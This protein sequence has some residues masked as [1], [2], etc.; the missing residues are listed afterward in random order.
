MTSF[1]PKAFALFAVLSSCVLGKAQES[2]RVTPAVKV[3]DKIQSAVLPVFCSSKQ[4]EM[5]AGSATVIH[6]SGFMLT[7]DH[8][9]TD[10]AGVVLIG[11]E[12][13]EYDVVGRLPERDVAILK[14]R[15]TKR[16][17]SVVRFGTS[18]DL[19]LGEPIVVGGN[20]GGRGIVFS[21]GTINS[22]M[23]EPS[24]PNILIKSYWRN[25]TAE[26]SI[27]RR[28]TT[29]GRP[30]FIQFDATTN[31]GNSGGPVVN[32]EA[33]LIGLVSQKSFSEEGINWAVPIDRI[34]SL[35]PH[36]VPSEEIGDFTT[37][38][39][40]D[41]LAPEALVESVSDNSPASNAGLKKGDVIQSVNGLP[42]LGGYEWYFA[43]WGH[44]PG[45]KLALSLKR[46]DSIESVE[47]QLAK[48]AVPSSSLK[49]EQMTE[50]VRFDFYNGMYP[51]MPDFSLLKPERSGNLKGIELEGVISKSATQKYAIVYKGFI[52][53][54]K[55]GLYRFQLSSDDGSKLY[56]NDRL[57]IDNDLG[58]PFQMLSRWARVPAGLVPFRLEYTDL[59]GDRGLDLT[60]ARDLSGTDKISPKFFTQAAQ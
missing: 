11:L 21:Q 26:L 7:A 47:M 16:V 48:T 55:E 57:L 3:I 37:G 14:L 32:F 24:W 10:A 28:R 5:H 42:L 36:L 31:R 1:L 52:D 20:P 9:T 46:Q 56:L 54:E 39:Q 15:D 59:G 19:M 17:K 38:V 13:F 2:G 35:I 8:V 33:A 40:I 53:F 45:D 27:D 4:G 6:P 12:R 18:D 41:V 34:R 51:S 44:K 60:I 22:R 58:H 50:G 25:E 23:I 43:L 49:K 29:G 30:D